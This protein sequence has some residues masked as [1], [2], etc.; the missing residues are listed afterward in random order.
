[1]FDAEHIQ[2][3]KAVGAGLATAS[4]IPA[5]WL[6]DLDFLLRIVLTL[7]GIMTGIY[8]LLYY[9]HKYEKDK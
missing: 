8:S 2:H 1:M 9:K 6:V 4:F 5:A 3:I 7:V